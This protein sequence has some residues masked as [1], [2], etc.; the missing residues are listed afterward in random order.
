M[1]LSLCDDCAVTAQA[2]S[3]AAQADRSP[4]SPIGHRTVRSVTTQADRSPHRLDRSPHSPIG[5]RTGSIGHRTVRSVTAQ[6]RSVTA[7]ARSVTAQVDRS[8]HR[9]D[10]SP[11]RP[12]GHRTLRL[13]KDWVHVAT[14]ALTTP[15]PHNVIHEKYDYV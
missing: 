10:R 13:V 12:I 11:H 15:P 7:Q 9:L 2:R 14:H 8:P 3:V 1:C 6:A 4:H 5:D